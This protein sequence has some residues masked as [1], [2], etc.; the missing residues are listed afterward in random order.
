M[1]EENMKVLIEELSIQ[2]KTFNILVEVLQNI[3]RHGESS[4]AGGK[5]GL[6]MISE[7]YT[8]FQVSAG[9]LINNEAV[10]ALKEK[11]SNLASL[12]LDELNDLYKKALRSEQGSDG[13]AGL[14]LID[15]FRDSNNQVEVDFHQVNDS[16]S[17]FSIEVKL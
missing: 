12:N 15:I 10:P 9:N 14:G 8:G 4:E 1:M 17:F 13:G 5:T 11:I 3:S 2:K 16:H 7:S 6:F